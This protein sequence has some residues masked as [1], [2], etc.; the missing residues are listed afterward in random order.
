MEIESQD[1]RLQTRLLL[2]RTKKFNW[3]SVRSSKNK[4]VEEKNQQPKLEMRKLNKNSLPIKRFQLSELFLKMAD[5]DYLVSQI[6]IKEKENEIPNLPDI[7][8]KCEH[9]NTPFFNPQLHKMHLKESHNI[10]IED[11][12]TNS[13]L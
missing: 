1:S 8:I 5:F 13:N 9:C 11:N 2:K 4:N 6:S 7:I 12:Q 10:I 3:G